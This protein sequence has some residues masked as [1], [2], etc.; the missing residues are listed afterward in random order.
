MLE[1]GEK[2]SQES[3]LFDES[4]GKTVSMRSKEEAHDYRYFPEPDLVPLEIDSKWI[5]EINKTIGELPQAKKA[6]YV[7]KFKLPE[8]DAVILTSDKDLAGFFEEA[9]KLYMS[10]KR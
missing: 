2:I 5:D 7:S 9:V 3:R 10:R 6:R 8:M 1:A 4:S